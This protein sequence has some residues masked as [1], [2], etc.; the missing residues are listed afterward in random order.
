MP[1]YS[2]AD[3]DAWV[4]AMDRRLDFVVRQSTND[5]LN[6][7]EIVP[8]I[9]RGGSRVRGTIPRDLGI[10]AN[11]LVSSLQ[12]STSLTAASEDSYVMV[13]GNMKAGDVATFGWGGPA[14]PYARAIHDGS[15]STPGTFWVDVAAQKW[16]GYVAG[17]VAKGRAV[18]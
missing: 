8:G 9:N 1:E 16:P 18:S 3:M 10:L 4:G 13:I 7:I 17:A 11:S 14:A 6:G 12:G 2:W 15:G 5:L